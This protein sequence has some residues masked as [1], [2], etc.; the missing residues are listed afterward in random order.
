MV[1]FCGDIIE[2]EKILI[3]FEANES[4]KFG[5]QNHLSTIYFNLGNLYYAIN[6]RNNTEKYYQ[7]ALEIR[8]KLVKL[9]PK[10]MN[11]KSGLAA[12]YDGMGNLYYSM[13]VNLSYAEDY[14]LKAQKIRE[15]LDSHNNFWQSNL[16]IHYRLLG[17]LYYKKNDKNNTKKYYQKALEISEKWAEQNPSNI[18][19]QNELSYCYYNMGKFYSKSKDFNNSKMYYLKALKIREKLVK[20]RFKNREWQKNLWN[21][22]YAL[23]TV[24]KEKQYLKKC[25]D[26]MYSVKKR[27]WLSARDKKL[28]QRYE[29]ELQAKDVQ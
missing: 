4:K 23:Y 12:S 21:N 17:N 6:D 9:Y 8:E 22:Y 28:L 19:W 20:H 26:Q 5:W 3:K 2:I 7:K 15:K 10:D 14:Y 11:L 13:D 24:T 27:G 16:S 25:I 18:P 1:F 29:K